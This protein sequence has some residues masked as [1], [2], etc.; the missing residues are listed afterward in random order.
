MPRRA[1][2]PVVLEMERLGIGVSRPNRA[3]GETAEAYAERLR[4]V[5]GFIHGE[6]TDLTSRPEYQALPDEE[7]RDEIEDLIRSVRAADTREHRAD[8]DQTRRRR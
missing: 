1:N 4:R 3:R 8:E 2:D 5:G 7:K 6:L